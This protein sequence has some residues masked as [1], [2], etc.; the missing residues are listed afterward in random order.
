MNNYDD[1]VLVS[2][3]QMLGVPERVRVRGLLGKEISSI[4][5]SMTNA[6]IDKV[7]Y[8]IIEP[9]VDVSLMCDED[10]V[11]ILHKARQLTFGDEIV[12][13]L[14]CPFCN[15]KET[16]IFNY[17]DF[18]VDYLPDNYLATEVEL[19]GH[20][21]KIKIPTRIDFERLDEFK[22]SEKL[23]DDSVFTLLLMSKVDRVD[24]KVLSLKEL[25]DF[26]DNLLGKDIMAFAKVLDIPLGLNTNK[27]L[28]CSNCGNTYKGGIG[29]SA[30]L[31]C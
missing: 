21:I 18:K 5:S 25:K 17:N 7:I 20:K 13:D 4:Y 11:L 15:H 1:L 9:K 23:E 28:V 8:E 29:L 6:S 19:S 2:K 31:F 27:D 12:Q 10:K 26:L 22:N 14:K 16:H 24:G 3:G 30:D